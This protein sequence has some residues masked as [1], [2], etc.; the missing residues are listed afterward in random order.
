MHYSKTNYY[1]K[2]ADF[3]SMNKSTWKCYWIMATSTQTG[4]YFVIKF[5]IW[6]RNQY[7]WGKWLQKDWTIATVQSSKGIIKYEKQALKKVIE[8]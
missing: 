8:Y 5:M 1:H 4:N 6:Y 3:V 2:K 7:H